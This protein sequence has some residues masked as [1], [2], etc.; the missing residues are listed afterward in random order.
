[1]SPLD[2]S[3]RSGQSGGQTNRDWFADFKTFISVNP[4][5]LGSV[6]FMLLFFSGDKGQRPEV[7][8]GSLGPHPFKGV[9]TLFDDPSSA[10]LS[11]AG[12]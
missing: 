5:A 10:P 7:A 9:W 4:F 8:E 3:A 1:M 12:S 2:N 11:W 6:T